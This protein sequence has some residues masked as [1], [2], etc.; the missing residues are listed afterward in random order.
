MN[1]IYNESKRFSKIIIN[2]PL[3]QQNLQMLD[4]V[5]LVCLVLAVLNDFDVDYNGLLAGILIF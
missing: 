2:L 5:Y 3:H 1:Y 4:L